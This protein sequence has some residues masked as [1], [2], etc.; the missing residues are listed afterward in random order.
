MRSFTPRP[1]RE[2]TGKFL[3]LICGFVGLSLLWFISATPVSGKQVQTVGR[4]ELE[5]LIKKGQKVQV[6]L[7]TGTYGEGKVEQVDRQRLVLHVTK[8]NDSRALAKGRQEI[9]LERLASV[10]F[11]AY[12]GNQ[13]KWLAV[14]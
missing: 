13:R 6:V 10:T 11:S 14:I 1:N 2:I 5:K 3:R 12:K 9:A 4:E 7:E 8:T